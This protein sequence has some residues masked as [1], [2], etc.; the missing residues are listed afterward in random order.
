MTET[1]DKSLTFTPVQISINQYGVAIT[2]NERYLY[3]VN[4]QYYGITPYDSVY[5]YDL[6]NEQLIT[7]ITD[8]SF[9]KIGRAH[10]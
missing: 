3:I 4:N 10:V 7:T 5:L 1:D 8:S 2:P 9:K 6:I